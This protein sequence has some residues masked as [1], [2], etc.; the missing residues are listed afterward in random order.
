M[1]PPASTHLLAVPAALPKLGPTAVVI[2]QAEVTGLTDEPP[3][4]RGAFAYGADDAS[5]A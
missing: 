5:A 3:S 1:T 2:G 4:P